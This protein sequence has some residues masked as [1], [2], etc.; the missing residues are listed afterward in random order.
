MQALDFRL[1]NPSFV[2]TGLASPYASVKLTAPTRALT[3][4]VSAAYFVAASNTKLRAHFGNAYRAPSLYER[5]GGGF[6]NDPVNGETVF[7]PFGDPRLSPD[8][9]NSLDAG[10]DQYV[11]GNR[12]RLEQYILRPQPNEF[13]LVT[14]NERDSRFDYFFYHGVFNAALPTDLSVALRQL[15]GTPNNPPQWFLTGYDT[16]RSNTQDNIVEIAAGGHPIDVNH[17]GVTGDAV[18]AYFDTTLNRYVTLAPGA[19]FYQTLFD[20]YS[21]AYDNTVTF[22]WAPRTGLTGVKSTADQVTTYLGGAYD[23]ALNGAACASNP[24]AP[25]VDSP[26]IHDRIK[27]AY[28]DGKIWDQYDTYLVD[29][30]GTVASL[31]DFAGL[32][33]G[34]PAFNASRLKWNFEE[35]ITSSFFNGRKIDL[36]IE[37]KTLIESG[38]LK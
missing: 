16:A 2:Y 28:G 24:P 26:L 20:T 37:P 12:V 6:S 10:V 19:K 35:V 30:K 18:G 23:C 13:K 4:D 31:G 7:T 22:S 15:G 17:D 14:L 3:G 33:P 1:A 36:V 29:D 27:E 32:Q 9:Y 8:R 25:S 38:L 21:I 5:F 34:T 11:F